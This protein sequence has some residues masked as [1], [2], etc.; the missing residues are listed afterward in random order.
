MSF[1]EF[2]ETMKERLQAAFP[3]KTV[4]VQEV[5]KNNDRKF[6]G[7]QVLTKG[8]NIAPCL[9][10]DGFYRDDLN[11]E[12][13]DTILQ[14]LKEAVHEAKDKAPDIGEISDFSFMRDKIFYTLINA[15]KNEDLL[16]V[17]PHILWNDL[18]IV[19]RCRVA[20]YDEG[21]TSFLIGDALAKKWNVTAEDLY[22]LAK[23]N[24]PKLF[25]WKV[26]G[27]TEIMG[28]LLGMSNTLEPIE[29]NV[30]QITE[31][32]DE[33]YVATNS[34]GI[35]G[36]NVLLYDDV[37]REFG[38]KCGSNFY[39]LPSSI[40]EVLLVPESDTMNDV[41]SLEQMVSEVN[42]T[43]VLPEE[44]L[45]DSVYYYDRATSELKIA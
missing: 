38:E 12:D 16:R 30:N 23:E 40:H 19:F 2:V 26:T 39:V 10:L 7:L 32:V 27:M 29:Q 34:T 8:S 44:I 41:H 13:L 14:A 1:R 28:Q 42:A 5:H 21:C 45:S 4:L 31:C 36:A 22:E 15:S 17:H 37:L 9:Y 24:T 3:E 35:N 11:E 25:S 6:T 43:E 18:A 20:S 33:A